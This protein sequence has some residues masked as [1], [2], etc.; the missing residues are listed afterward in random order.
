MSD[1][2]QW[3]RWPRYVTLC[4]TSRCN[5]RCVHCSSGAGGGGRGDL[6]TPEIL[7]LLQELASLGV[8]QV[9]ISGGEPL[10]HPDF[11]RIAEA[12]VYLGFST[13]IGTNGSTVTPAVARQLKAI[14]VNRV[15]VSLDGASAT[16]HDA[17]RRVP[18]LF[19]KAMLAIEYLRKA[20][21]RVHVCMTPTRF[22]YQELRALIRLS[23]DLGVSRFNVSQFV[24]LGR[25][26]KELDLS[27]EEWCEVLSVWEEERLRFQQQME[28]TAHEAQLAMASTSVSSMPGFQGCQ[29][30]RGV[31]CIWSDGTVVPCVMLGLP[32]GNVR[33][34]S[35]QRIWSESE[36]LEDLRDLT[37]LSEPCRS[38]SHRS[39]CGGCRGVAFA[40]SGDYLGADRHCWLAGECSKVV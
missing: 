28:F 38:C 22:N 30:G 3:P 36:V 26:S 33:Q 18:G 21:V 9:G 13:G 35:F 10:L 40:Y 12:T 31:A 15:Q 23:A 25:G 32:V 1:L 27:P 20:G 7:E 39:K 11:W 17:F 8:Y 5:A 4:I 14:G 2:P 19:R 6:T 29:A 34:A 16:T 37:R 24:P